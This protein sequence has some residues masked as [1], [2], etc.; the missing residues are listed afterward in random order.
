[1][2]DIVELNAVATQTTTACASIKQAEETYVTETAVNMAAGVTPGI[3][4]QANSEIV[5]EEEC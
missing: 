3:V 4:I 1:M 5:F 2:S